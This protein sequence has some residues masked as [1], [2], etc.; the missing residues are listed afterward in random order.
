MTAPPEPG[1]DAARAARSSAPPDDEPDYPE[2]RIPLEST[3]TVWRHRPS[4]T[5][6]LGEPGGETG[7]GTPPPDEEAIPMLTEVLDRPHA[8]EG[9][10]AA[11]PGPA[12]PPP[13]DLDRIALQVQ[14]SVLETL[15]LRTGTLLEAS[16]DERLHALIELSTERLIDEIRETLR[17]A[18]RDAVGRAISEELARVH[19]RMDAP[20][21]DE[22]LPGTARAPHLT[23]PGQ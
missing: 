15:Q 5:T 23:G 20:D 6:R 3:G 12:A 22:P 17:E 9:A 19:R 10:T 2:L 13:P 21:G 16:L 18:I 7:I 14:A 1:D 8:R 11:A 4:L